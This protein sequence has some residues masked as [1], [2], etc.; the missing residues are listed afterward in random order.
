MSMS[1]RP[2]RRVPSLFDATHCPHFQ[3]IFDVQFLR[4]DGRQ[5]LRYARQPRRPALHHEQVSHGNRGG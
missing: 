4:G 3:G 1:Y 5:P 2:Y